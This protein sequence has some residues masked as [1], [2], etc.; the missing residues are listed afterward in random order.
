MD[1]ISAKDKMPY[2]YEPV[3]ACNIP[4]GASEPIWIK[5]WVWTGSQ[6]GCPSHGLYYAIDPVGEVTHWAEIPIRIS[7]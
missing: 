1:W 2:E 4:E 6:W 7:N 5:N 3:Y